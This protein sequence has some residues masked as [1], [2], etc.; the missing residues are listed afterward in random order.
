MRGFGPRFGL[1]STVGA[2]FVA[3]GARV[4]RRGA[5]RSPPSA[6]P[7]AGSPAAASSGAGRA[8]AGSESAGHAS[9]GRAASIPAGVPLVVSLVS[10]GLS[11]FAV[12]VDN[13]DP[14]VLLTAPAWVR[15]AQGPNDAWLYVQP[16][17]VSTGRND[18]VEVITDITLRVEPL[19]GGQASDF[20]WDEQGHGIPTRSPTACHGSSPETQSRWW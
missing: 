1:L 7:P 8:V 20:V 15:V 13:R 10:L 19:N 17:F 11:G 5:R 9:G 2:V 18:R 3:I 6:V 16:R 14:E 12:F 4:A